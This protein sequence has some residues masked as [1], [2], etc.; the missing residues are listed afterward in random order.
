MKPCQILAIFL[1]ITIFYLLFTSSSAF[2]EEGLY[3]IHSDHLGSTALVSNEAGNLVSQQN[4]YPY[5][6]TRN[7]QGFMPGEREYTSQVSDQAQT[8]LYYYNARYYDP[9]TG[10]FTQADDLDDNLNRYQYVNSNPI[11]FD[12]PTG[13]QPEIRSP[14][15]YLRQMRMLYAVRTNEEVNRRNERINRAEREEV[16]ITRSQI[17]RLEKGHAQDNAV[18]LYVPD[19]TA[20]QFEREFDRKTKYYVPDHVYNE[21]ETLAELMGLSN[22]EKRIIYSIW[23]SE[24]GWKTIPVPE[25]SSSQSSYYHGHNDYGYGG[26]NVSTHSTTGT[27]EGIYAHDAPF[28]QGDNYSRNVGVPFLEV[29]DDPYYHGLATLSIYSFKYNYMPR[30]DCGFDEAVC[31]YN[32]YCYSPRLGYKNRGVFW[33]AWEELEEEHVD[34]N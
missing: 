22:D 25:D 7:S 11:L 14:E 23:L 3:F 19:L 28:R 30:N 24:S 34:A 26:I 10:L 20:G 18:R 27:E 8:G 13:F 2:A 12:D 32:W 16:L 4:Y 33:L 17:D 6:S 29:A 9:V 15:W 5:G 31:A 1:L 21:V